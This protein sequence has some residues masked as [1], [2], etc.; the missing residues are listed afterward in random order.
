MKGKGFDANVL[1]VRRMI[2]EF[3]GLLFKGW[4]LDT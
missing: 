4:M 1:R 2:V 3:E